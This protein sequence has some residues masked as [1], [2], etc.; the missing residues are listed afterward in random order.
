MWFNIMIPWRLKKYLVK[1]KKK[2]DGDCK[3][4]K[5]TSSKDSHT[6]SGKGKQNFVP[7]LSKRKKSLQISLYERAMCKSKITQYNVFLCNQFCIQ[8]EMGT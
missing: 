6:H 8:G 1:K 5:T 7:L 3:L 2:W 4:L